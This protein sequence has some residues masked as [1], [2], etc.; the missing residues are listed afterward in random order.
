MSP[1]C[2]VI[3][4]INQV[5]LSRGREKEHSFL[6]EGLIISTFTADA[7]I[8]ST[9]LCFFLI[10]FF[11]ALIVFFSIRDYLHEQIQI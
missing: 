6:I 5:M 10:K 11:I 3:K 1:L 9:F 8:Q 7:W 4:I 2:V